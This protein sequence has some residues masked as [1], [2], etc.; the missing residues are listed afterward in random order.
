MTD[1]TTPLWFT[2][3]QTIG[4]IGSLVFAAYTVRRGIAASQLQNYIQ[5][6]QYHREVWRMTLELDDLERVRSKDIPDTEFNL[7]Q[8]EKQFLTFVFLHITCSYEMSKRNE[9]ISIDKLK[10]DISEFIGY[11]LVLKF[12]EQNKKYYN[13]DF[14]M[15]ITECRVLRG[16]LPK[17]FD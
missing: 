17:E 9:M 15:F 11:P 10:Q 4:I 5:L 12:W 2:A 3:V 8:K 7:T 16:S 6:T 13:D 1:P 14:S